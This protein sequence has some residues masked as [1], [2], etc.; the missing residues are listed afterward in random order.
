MTQ[1]GSKFLGDQGYTPIEILRNAY[2]DDIYLETAE[3]VSGVPA[4]WPG[5]NLQQGS[6]GS[7][8]R[9][10]QEQ[11]NAISNNYPA[12]QKIR[13]DGVFGPE[14]VEAVKKFQSIFGLPPNGI[15]DYPTWYR[16]SD[17]FVAVT[18]LAELQ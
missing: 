7:N 6:Q 10:I 16:I 15:V 9:I 5:S 4:S 11:L 1:W 17:I 18:R 8:V 12:I 2:G 13:V 14:T 3:E